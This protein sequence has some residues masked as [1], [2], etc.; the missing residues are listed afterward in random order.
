MSAEGT[1]KRSEL[2]SPMVQAVDLHFLLFDRPLHPELF[3]HYA[4]YRV[5]QGRYHADI[6]IVG[7]SH[8]VTVTC[9]RRSLTELLSR[10]IDLLPTRGGVSRFRLKGERDQERRLP[11]GWCHMVSTQVETMDEPLY[12]SVHND[13]WR[14]A[15]KRGW[16]VPYE[17]WAKGDLVPFSYIDHEARDAEFHVHAYHTFPRERTLV[18]TQSIFELPA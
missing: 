11:D 2:Q 9:R 7:L 10:E 12:K 18:K 3:H 6:W 16:F 15:A 17:A 5:T 13:L 1:M 4:S 8:V 14:H